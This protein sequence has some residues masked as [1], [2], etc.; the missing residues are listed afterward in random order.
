MVQ[1]CAKTELRSTQEDAD[2]RLLLHTYIARRNGCATVVISSDDTDVFVLCLASH[3]LDIVYEVR[4]TCP[5][6]V[7]RHHYMLF[8]ATVQSCAEGFLGY[9][10]LLVVTV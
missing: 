4:N 10:L 9:T 2:K 7:Y 1:Y 5:N 6:K 3:S 8:S